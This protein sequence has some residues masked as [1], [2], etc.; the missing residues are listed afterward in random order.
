MSAT[1]NLHSWRESVRLACRWIIDR[2]M[3]RTKERD[4]GE[5]RFRFLSAYSD[6]RGAF[7][8][9]YSAAA[10]RWDVFCPI[11]HG[12]QGVKAL[13][14]AYG[15]LG[16]KEY[17]DAARQAAEFILRHQVV[18]RRSKDFGFIPAYE[19][20]S[21]G[22]NTSA[23]IESLDGLFI[24]SELSGER[25][26][27][28]AAV[29][30]L[31]WVQ[32][33]MFLPDEGLFLDD[34]LPGEGVILS[35]K[36]FSKSGRPILDD[37]VFLTGARVAGDDS[38]RQVAVRTADRVLQDEDPPGNWK[39]YPPANASKGIIHP[40]HA[41]WWGRPLWM[42]Y[43]ETGQQK[44]LDACRRSCAWYVKAMR[45]DGGIFRITDP[46]FKTP[47]FGHAT[48]GAACAAIMWLDMAREFG[49][50]QW[51]APLRTALSF[52]RSM[53]FSKASDPD[54]QGAVLEKVLPPDGSDAPPWQLRD[55]GTFFYV[56]AVCL[57]L[58]EVP[59]FLGA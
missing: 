32:R 5:S 2:S 7:K 41:Y 18:D 37:G 8:G 45:T 56:Q 31:R 36:R 44:Y 17:L 46:D 25:R 55:I 28:D 29:A 53:Q 54:L 50:R 10:R 59:Q 27:A 1:E 38:L 51:D 43:K 26:Y 35:E 12:G 6:W 21:E 48:S 30:A 49:D 14:L 23:I 20:G 33:T 16:D 57:A 39:T 11:W 4:F 22:V 47:S 19:H 52:C 13:A 24:L 3:I 15:A 42:V 40:R 9:E 58:K 34:Y